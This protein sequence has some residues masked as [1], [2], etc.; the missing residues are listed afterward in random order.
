M[1]TWLDGRKFIGSW[2]NNNMEGQGFYTWPDGRTYY[3]EYKNDKKDGFGIYRWSDGRIYEGWWHKGKQYGF[4]KYI[5]TKDIKFGLWENGRRIK[6]LSKEELH[7]IEK[8]DIKFKD[9]LEN[10]ASFAIVNTKSKFLPPSNFKYK[11]KLHN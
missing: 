5:S 1:Y 2:E 7:E 11:D 8:G 10:A 3:G 9:W 6:W 4:G